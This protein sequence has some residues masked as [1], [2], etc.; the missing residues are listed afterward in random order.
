MTL[1]NIYRCTDRCVLGRVIPLRKCACRRT[2]AGPGD[3]AF[4]NL[5]T[6]EKAV[7]VEFL[8]IDNLTAHGS[9]PAHRGDLCLFAKLLQV[10]KR[11]SSARG[12]RA[13]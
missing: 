9:L 4:L 5:D 10:A 11:R 7:I 6:H 13:H 8:T 1:A 12:R 3:A 2:S